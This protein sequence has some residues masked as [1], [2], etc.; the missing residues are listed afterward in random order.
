M[1]PL[2]P[3]V[4]QRRA[5]AA[6]TDEV[7]RLLSASAGYVIGSRTPKTIRRRGDDQYD[8][9]CNGNRSLP[10]GSRI[11]RSRPTHQSTTHDGSIRRVDASGTITT[12]HYDAN[13]NAV[14][15]RTDGDSGTGPWPACTRL[16]CVYESRSPGREEVEHFD[17]LGRYDRRR[18]LDAPH[19]PRCTSRVVRSED[20][21]AHG[22]DIEYDSASRLSSVTDPADNTVTLTYDASSNITRVTEMELSG[23]GLPPETYA[24]DYEYDALDRLTAV[25]D[26][27][28]GRQE[29]DYDRSIRR[30]GARRAGIP[31]A[32]LR[33]LGR[34]VRSEQDL[35]TTEPVRHGRRDPVTTQVLDDSR[36]RLRDGSQRPLTTTP[37][38]PAT[39]VGATRADGTGYVLAWNWQSDLGSVTRPDGTVV[40]QAHDRLG[41]RVSV[42]VTPGPGVAGTTVESYQYDGM[43]RLVRAEDDDSTITRTYDSLSNAWTETQQLAGGPPRTTQR[44]TTA[45]ASDEPHVLDGDTV[46]YNNDALGRPDLVL[47]N[48]ALVRTT[49]IRPGTRQAV[50]R[51]PGP[52]RPFL[53]RRSARDGQ[54]DVS[55]LGSVS[56]RASGT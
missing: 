35:T 55:S 43:S 24:T 29:M 27:G 12:L 31:R 8:Y 4:A 15:E 46:I 13:H 21:N 10:S 53:R 56:T 23:P 28:G 50:E 18:P 30:C 26:G 25:V 14:S 44:L 42:D 37:T 17:V 20:D 22:T 32:L 54:V 6:A 51:S 45:W 7:V 33:R 16:P 52:S 19:I 2:P 47:V 34:Q 48:G 9:D 3:P 41:H 49:I 39:A 11:Q 36:A 38:T 1:R 5:T 40:V